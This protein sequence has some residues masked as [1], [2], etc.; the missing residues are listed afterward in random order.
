MGTIT[1]TNGDHNIIVVK[2]NS[3]HQIAWQKKMMLTDV[4]GKILRNEKISF[5]NNGIYKN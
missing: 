2:Y 5:D 3:L 4:T 1:E